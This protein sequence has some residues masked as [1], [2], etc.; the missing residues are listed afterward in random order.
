MSGPIPQKLKNV[1][2]RNERALQLR[3]AI[4]KGTGKTRVRLQEGL[5][6]EIEDGQWKLTAG[7]SENSGGANGGP[8]PGTFGRGALG[9]CLAMGYANWAA[10]LDVPIKAI[11]VEVEADYDIRGS[12]GL[13]DLPPGYLEVR[14]RVRIESDAPEEAIRKVLDEAD[15]HSPWFDIYK[16][17]QNLRRIIEIMPVES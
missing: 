16:R 6:C 17:P 11:E 9:A 7:A 13:A 8:D 10:K 15:A 3:P 5:T 2:E 4:G 1:L 12:Y 14:Y